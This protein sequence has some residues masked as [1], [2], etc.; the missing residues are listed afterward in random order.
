MY[1]STGKL[2]KARKMD[3][4]SRQE[5]EVDVEECEEATTEHGEESSEDDND[6]DD[7]PPIVEFEDPVC[8]LSQSRARV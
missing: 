2:E 3:N 1:I 7:E 6:L 4:E 8:E 5:E